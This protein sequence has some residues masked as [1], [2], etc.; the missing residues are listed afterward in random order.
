[1]KINSKRLIFIIIVLVLV[2]ILS[3]FALK[4]RDSYQTLNVK[5]PAASE[6]GI[7]TLEPSV[8][9]AD[10]GELQALE[11]NKLYSGG[12]IKKLR[13]KKG[14]YIAK[15]SSLNKDFNDL[16]EKIYL[17]DAP[18]DYSPTLNYS[19]LKL[20]LVAKEA[21]PSIDRLLKE[22]YPAVMPQYRVQNVKAYALGNWFSVELVPLDSVNEDV[23]QV[24]LKKE[25]DKLTLVTDP[26]QII[27]SKAVY[28]SIPDIVFKDLSSRFTI[29]E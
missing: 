25:R 17:E 6:V 18:V 19:S 21:A 14:V 15:T 29:R 3:L 20:D 23:Y 22:R 28:P 8:D 9:S 1:M 26:P 11:K 27:I 12:D 4:R 13:L 16:T 24:V 2:L 10:G 7:Y 5:P